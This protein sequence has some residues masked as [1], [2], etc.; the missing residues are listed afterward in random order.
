[1]STG[2]K[3]NMERINHNRFDIRKIY[4]LLVISYFGVP[5]SL[6]IAQSQVYP[7]HPVNKKIISLQGANYWNWSVDLAKNL[8]K[9]QTGRPFMNGVIFHT[10]ATYGQPGLAFN[11]EVWTDSSLRFDKLATIAG[12]CTNFTDNFILVWGH[13]GNTGPDFFNDTLWSQIIRNTELLGKAVKIAGCKGI[14]FDP[15]FYSRKRTYSPWWYSKTGKEGFSS[16]YAGRGQSYEIVRA[17]ARQRGREYVQA[18]QVQMPEIKILT[19]FL[20]GAVWNYCYGDMNT[21]SGSEYALLG[22]FADGM[23]EGLNPRSQLIDGNE[24]SFYCNDTRQY[25]TETQVQ[26]D[27][28]TLRILAPSKVCDSTIIAKWNG[29]GQ[30][31]MSVYFDYAYNLYEPKNWSTPE[32]Q[33]KW[34]IHN[35]YHSLL[36]TDEYVWLY[37]EDMDFWTGENAPAVPDVFKDME[38]AIGKFNTGEP[39]GYDMHGAAWGDKQS[40]F[41]TAPEISI[42]GQQSFTLPGSIMI[43]PQISPGEEVL[44][45][46]YFANSLFIGSSWTSPFTIKH[47]FLDSDYTIVARAYLKNGNHN[48]SAPLHLIN[49]KFSVI[50]NLNDLMPA[51]VQLYPNPA[52]CGFVNIDFQ[53]NNQ[54]EAKVNIINPSGQLV[55]RH[56]IHN[57]EKFISIP[58]ESF[59]G[60]GLYILQIENSMQERNLKVVIL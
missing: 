44:K 15:E 39:L 12:K 59:K 51:G 13:A 36:A 37:V 11:N 32:Y 48:T 20:Y 31:A 41:Y 29:Q 21:L 55:S 35:V 24:S 25:Y 43:T 60:R 46:D 9:M 6:V 53:Q 42:M 17:K 10:G 19:T 5:Y 38:D 28:Y 23:L 4:I 47:W 27:Y 45:V 26:G 16:P 34:M 14:M 57:N 49:G 2:V 52:S 58:V 18:L 3:E 8:D 1:M 56:D 30:V 40:I 33:S 7:Y 50:T 54:G 22:A